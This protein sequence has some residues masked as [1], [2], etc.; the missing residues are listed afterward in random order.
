MN[1]KKFAEY[2]LT[3]NNTFDSAGYN[4]SIFNF[5]NIYFSDVDWK[6]WPYE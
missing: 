4:V 5:D 3:S 1:K 2:I 6:N